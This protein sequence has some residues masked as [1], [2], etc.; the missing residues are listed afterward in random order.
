VRG[1][2][3]PTRRSRP[4]IPPAGPLRA[5]R[6]QLAQHPYDSGLWLGGVEALRTLPPGVDAVVSLC[7]VGPD[8]IPTDVEHV[9][10]RLIDSADTAENPNFC[11]VLQD[12]VAVIE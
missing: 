5:Q 4:K 12:S 10:V 3:S 1:R 11:Y 6:L 9:E 2:P 8:D 7:R